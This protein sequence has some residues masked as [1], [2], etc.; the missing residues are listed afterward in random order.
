M[1]KFYKVTV[2]TLSILLVGSACENGFEEM[3]TDPFNPTQTS[4]SFLFNGMLSS[5]SHRG[6]FI[7]YV[8]SERA[9]QWSQLA[10][11][12][13]GGGQDL[14]TEGSAVGSS[15]LTVADRGINVQWGTF[16][17]MLRSYRAMEE[18]FANDIDPDRLVNQKAMANIIFAYRSLRM[19][20]IYGDMPWSQA[21][22]GFTAGIPRPE[23]DTQEFIYKECLKILADAASSINLNAVGSVTAAGNAYLNFGAS[24]TIY[25]NDMEMWKKLAQSLRLRYG[26]RILGVDNALATSTVTSAMQGPLFEGSEGLIFGPGSAIMSGFE[27]FSDQRMGSRIWRELNGGNAAAAADGSDV[28][29]PR[30]FGWFEPNKDFEWVPLAQDWTDPV[31]VDGFPTQGARRQDNDGLDPINNFRGSHSGFNWY[32]V[33]N[34]GNSFEYHIWGGEVAL[35]KAEA[36]AQG[37]VSGNA[38]AWYEE[39]VEA[40]I[41]LEHARPTLHPDYSASVYPIPD[42]TDQMVADYLSGYGAYDGSVKQIQ[43]QRWLAYF[44]NT[45]Q[46]WALTRR[47]GNQIE[48]DFVG[49]TGT[50]AAVPQA[51]RVNYPEDEVINNAEAYSAASSRIGGDEVTT[52]MWWTK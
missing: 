7:L 6:D 38:Q 11:V 47:A 35:M 21:G 13:N 45:D 51:M 49:A 41:R 50:G 32:T 9:Y 39:G 17:S 5:T 27:W 22:K 18:I 34:S 24:D 36:V 12:R 25:G 52:S 29:D 3:N 16:Y 4:S 37:V 2:L 30:I 8:W 31:S 10:A 1:N 40:S 28:V 43:T 23:Y 14:N 44:F 15:P 33:E 26:L 48:L 20:D 19:T 46:A 42:L